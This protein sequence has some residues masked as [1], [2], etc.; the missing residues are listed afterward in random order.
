MFRETTGE[1]GNGTN[2]TGAAVWW[3]H[4]GKTV[5][6]FSKE[7]I[8]EIQVTLSSVCFGLSFVGQRIAATTEDAAD[9]MTY[10]SWRF[11]VSVLTLIIIKDKLKSLIKTNISQTA[12]YEQ[13]QIPFLNYLYHLAKYFSIKDENFH[14]YFWGVLGGLIN[15]GVQACQQYGLQTVPAGKAALING[16]FV[17]VTPFLESFLPYFES[18]INITSWCAIFLS[19]IGT[20]F[21]STPE[22]GGFGFGEFLLVLSMLGCCV[23]ILISDVASKRVDCIEVTFIELTTVVIFS[24]IFSIWMNPQFWYW[25]LPAL[26]SGLAM[27]ICVGLS[28]AIGYSLGTLGQMHIPSHRASVLY[29]LE[30]AYTV[31]FGY[32]ILG[33]DFLLDLLMVSLFK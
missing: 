30:G 7:L 31:I 27:V 18:N 3:D 8:C 23:G 1:N 12:D 24:T 28:E 17:V 14:L 29:G 32:L 9:P 6:M 16:L 10:N 26:Q 33:S 19:G 2:N 21:L 15:F 11:M 22:S 4:Q 25:P 5:L 20:Y 13:D